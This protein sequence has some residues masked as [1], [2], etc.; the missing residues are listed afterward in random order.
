MVVRVGGLIHRTRR[1]LVFIVL[2]VAALATAARMDAQFRQRGFLSARKATSTDFD[3]EFHFCRVA[4]GSDPR[5]DGAG[6]SVDFPRA[7]INLSI[8][9]SELTKTTISRSS[10]GEP[11]NLLLQLTD[12]ELFDC[13][14]IMMTE[15]GGASLSPEE[16][17]QLRAYL[18]KGGFLWA[19]DFWGSYAWEWWEEQLRAVLPADKYPLVDLT[20]E[21]P[22]YHS[23]FEVKQ[24][25]QIPSIG[26]WE[27]N[28]GS[29]SER[30]ADSAT[31]HTRAVLDPHGRIMVLITHNTDFGDA[32]EREADDPQYFLQMS[33]P[34]YAFGIN[35][36][37][38]AMTH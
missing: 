28:G 33:V 3:G 2:A 6:W 31:V 11:N 19:D 23:Q 24:T 4:F 13:P 5:G 9:L 35:A 36:L 38:Y 17:T 30:G 8:R 26:F 10:S 29:T 21:H 16:Q 25:P 12:P 27:G 14:F 34:G 20:P 7:D 1:R 37:L 22:L 15:V 32:F 18:D